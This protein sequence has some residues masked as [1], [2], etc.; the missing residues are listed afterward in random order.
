MSFDLVFDF[1]ARVG[2]QVENVIWLGTRE[3]TTQGEA[4][5]ARQGDSKAR[6][7][8]SKMLRLLLVLSSER[9]LANK[10]CDLA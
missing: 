8:D 1:C 6:L 9:D 10:V 2:I 5:L 3:L 4:G 7:S